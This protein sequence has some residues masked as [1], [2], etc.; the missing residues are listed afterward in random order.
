M[1]KL[2]L[3]TTALAALLA[4]PQALAKTVTVQILKH[5]FSPKTATVAQ[6]DTVVWTNGDKAK[7][8]V[9]AT[10]GS[11]QSPVLAPGATYSHVFPANGTFNYR[12]ALHNSL[13]G[14]VVVRTVS[15]GAS[16]TVLTYGTSTRLAGRVSNGRAGEEVTI[17]ATPFAQPARLIT[18]TTQTGGYWSLRVFPLIQTRYEASWG[19]VTS[20]GSKTVLVRPRLSL[21]RLHNG[22]FSV[23]LFDLNQL[24]NNYV[25]ISRWS[26]AR[27]R[28]VHVTRIFLNPTNREV[29]WRAT[30]RLHVRS[31]T[32]LKAF[33]TGYQAGPG[34]LAASSDPVRR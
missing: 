28:Y 20:Q 27:G 21:R 30:F 25:W 7:H 14:A 3:V 22:F 8:Q 19:P 1:R 12:G 9:V 5:G 2:V 34:Y 17:R 10:D 15:L 24:P 11:F 29:I 16:R 23:T 26:P 13:K 33:I 4:A 31:G 6:N 32:K 18:A